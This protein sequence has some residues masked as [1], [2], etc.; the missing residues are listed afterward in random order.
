MGTPT[1]LAAD[2]T[3]D[4]FRLAVPAVL[5]LSRS[6]DSVW[7][8]GELEDAGV[9]RAAEPMYSGFRI[10]VTPNWERIELGPSVNNKQTERL[11]NTT[12]ANS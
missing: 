1:E 9:G 11:V 2:K 7:P 5:S 10:S 3:L 6:S 12:L 4:R 8:L